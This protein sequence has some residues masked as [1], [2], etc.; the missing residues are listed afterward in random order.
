MITLLKWPYTGRTCTCYDRRA[1]IQTGIPTLPV[2]VRAVELCVEFIILVHVT[3]PSY[4]YVG[5]RSSAVAGVQ[6]HWKIHSTLGN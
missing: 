5:E 2:L 4:L 3:E 6:R 1:S